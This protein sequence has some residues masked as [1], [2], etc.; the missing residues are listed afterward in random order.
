VQLDCNAAKTDVEKLLEVWP[1][2]PISLK[3][4]LSSDGD[5]IITKLQY[6]DRIVGIDL[7]NLTG[8]QLERCAVFMQAPFPYLRSL[9]L[10]LHPDANRSPALTEE[11][12]AGSA[13][14]LRELT[15]MNVEFPT[16]PKLLLSSRDLVTL[17]LGDM[18]STEHISP[19]AIAT[20]LSTLT[21]LQNLRIEFPS[22]RSFSNPRSPSCPPLTRA[23]LPHQENCI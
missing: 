12:F 9:C 10:S 14:R 20:C 8:I 17:Y 4:R 1:P 18:T 16:L 21:R 23:V 7:A 11:F 6:R 13:P 2:L 15:L 19:D 22:Q 3:S 5:G